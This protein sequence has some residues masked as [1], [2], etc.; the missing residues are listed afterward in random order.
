MADNK[1]INDRVLSRITDLESHLVNLIHPLQNLHRLAEM[2]NAI[3]DS[4]YKWKIQVDNADKR[5]E[6]AKLVG[7]KFIEKVCAEL[8]KHNFSQTASEIK[9][10]GNR[11]HNIETAL[12]KIQTDGVKKDV[13]ISVLIDGK[14]NQKKED[15]EAVD[16]AI[17]ELF[18]FFKGSPSVLKYIKS[19]ISLRSAKPK[20]YVEELG[21]SRERFY[22]VRHRAARML[23]SEKVNKILPRI[24]DEKFSLWLA[25]ISSQY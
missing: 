1:N 21:I 24:K 2:L 20:F 15:D 18:E 23:R 10:I 13:Q 3:S 14:T 7:E 17:R 12:M 19:C 9:Y 5:F 4:V 8:A 25:Y 6:Q 22:Q 16:P 11:L